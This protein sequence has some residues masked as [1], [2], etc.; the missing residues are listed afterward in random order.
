MEN[1]DKIELELPW[2]NSLNDMYGY[3]KGRVVLK[4]KGKD[5][6][7]KVFR[8]VFSKGCDYQIDVPIVVN[9]NLHPPTHR[10]Y[11][12][13]NFNKVLFD[14]LTNAGVWKDDSH[15]VEAHIYK[16]NV[17]VGGRIIIVIEKK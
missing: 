1:F 14:A 15:I 11:D 17:S 8:I 6:K 16:R 7:E 10:A 13:D 9:I 12:I 2:P 3:F 5:Y 4:K